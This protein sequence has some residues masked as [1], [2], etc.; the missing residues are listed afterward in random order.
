MKTHFKQPSKPLIHLGARSS[1]L[2][3]EIV[4]LRSDS[5][6]TYITLSDGSTILTSTTMGKIEKRLEGY[7]FFRPNRSTVVNLQYL[8]K[9]KANNKSEA[10][11][12]IRADKNST[13]LNIKIS[14]RRQATF[15]A[16]INA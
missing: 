9:Y 5:N 3:E 10:S 4:L 11:L 7:N 13:R 12:S 1:A 14:R 8:E 16:N 15:F 2:P 6:Y